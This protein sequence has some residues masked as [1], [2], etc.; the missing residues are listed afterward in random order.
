MA[1]AP[2]SSA[3]IT[4]SL[5][6][7]SPPAMTG[8]GADR[9]Q[10]AE[11]LGHGAGQDLH[12]IRAV[13]PLFRRE[14][15][16]DVVQGQRVDEEK[17]LDG[18]QPHLPGP[19]N[20]GGLGG[21]DPCGAGVLPDE[22]GGHLPARQAVHQVGVDEKGLAPPPPPG[23]R[24][25][26]WCRWSPHR[27]KITPQS[28]S[29]A[30][31]R[32]SGSLTAA[33]MGL[34]ARLSVREKTGRSIIAFLFSGFSAQEAGSPP[35]FYQYTTGRSARQGVSRRT[36]GKRHDFAVR[37]CYNR[38]SGGP[39]FRSGGRKAALNRMSGGRFP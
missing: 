21:D 33:M 13:L 7:I 25:S 22:I 18:G 29:S 26:R 14:K 2:A 24:G 5:S 19:P 38:F 31:S 9:G 12:H 6:W 10:G 23:P 28:E 20:Q 37:M 11:N 34:P 30:R 1:A 8:T 39:L 32:P 27:R 17:T 36:R 15:P 16:P 3:A 4:S 35:L